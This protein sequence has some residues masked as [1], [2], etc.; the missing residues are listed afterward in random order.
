MSPTNMDKVGKFDGSNY[1]M[2]SYKMQM[3]LTAKGLWGQVD[4]SATIDT[5]KMSQAQALIVLR[6]E[7]NQL[8]HVMRAK[9]PGEVWSVLEKMHTQKDMSTK[10][11]LKEKY[12]T[13]RYN[14]GNITKHLEDLEKL[15]LDMEI[16]GCMPDE[17]DICATLLRSLP[18]SFESLVQA[19]RFSMY[20]ITYAELSM[21]IKSE[22]TRLQDQGEIQ[23]QTAMFAKKKQFKP[24][25]DKTKIKCFNCGKW[26]T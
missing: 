20:K 4:G 1:H 8:I 19:V 23:E 6:L 16:A 26:A 21:K 17:S 25:F 18:P 24:K 3:L 14:N 2:W 9:T 13:F 15:V 7:D 10:L 5:D 12:A 11:W 22:E